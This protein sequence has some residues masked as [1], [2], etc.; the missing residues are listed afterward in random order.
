MQ[1]LQHKVAG[2]LA[3]KKQA[4]QLKRQANKKKIEKQTQLLLN[5]Q[6]GSKE[7]IA[8]EDQPDE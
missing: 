4:N 8:T 1:V 7:A 3:R 6:Q 2:V 5:N